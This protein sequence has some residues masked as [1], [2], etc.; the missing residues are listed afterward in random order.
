[1]LTRSNDILPQQVYTAN[2][3]H[4][5]QVPEQYWGRERM[6]RA[7]KRTERIVDP[8][9][10]CHSRSRRYRRTATTARFKRI[11][12]LVGAATLVILAVAYK[13]TSQ[14]VTPHVQS[15]SSHSVSSVPIPDLRAEAHELFAHADSVGA[16]A[17]GVAEGT[18]TIEGEQTESW[19]SHIDSGNGVINQ[20]TFAWQMEAASP[21]AADQAAI[22]HIQNEV[23]PHILQDAQREGITLEPEILVQAVDLWNQAP[24]AGADF[25]ENFKQ[26]Q[27]GSQLEEALLCARI[28]SYYDPVTGELEAPGFDND[29]AW[30][31][32][33]QRRRLNTIQQVLRF[34]Q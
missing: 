10:R 17:I 24:E 16:I 6:C 11:R 5:T 20:G 7:K 3:L 8:S 32:Q 26:C 15:D 23:I 9:R 4:Q 1:M 29:I 14:D 27:R 34:N 18:R 22:H 13:L 31:E 2:P 19:S 30:L 25:V 12:A 21:E 28:Y 33:D